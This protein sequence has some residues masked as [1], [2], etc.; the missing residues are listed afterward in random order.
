MLF[1]N[2]ED[3]DSNEFGNSVLNISARVKSLPK[4]AP[5][6]SDE[7]EIDQKLAPKIAFSPKLSDF[8]TSHEHTEGRPPRCTDF[9]ST[10]KLGHGDGL[11]PSAKNVTNDHHF[12]NQG[13]HDH[14][15]VYNIK[16]D[17]IY[18]LGCQSSCV[19]RYYL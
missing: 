11:F 16:F 1:S 3:F 15:L 4:K 19:N 13:K 18:C 12:K 8:E 9:F 6:V 5:F 7:A 17:E 14:I 10:M 2:S